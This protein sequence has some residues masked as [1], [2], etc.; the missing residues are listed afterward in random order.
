MPISFHWVLAPAKY[1]LGCVSLNTQALILT[2]HGGLEGTGEKEFDANHTDMTPGHYFLRGGRKPCVWV[3]KVPF[4]VSQEQRHKT[5]DWWLCGRGHAFQ[6]SQVLSPSSPLRETRWQ[7]MGETLERKPLPGRTDRTEPDTQIL[8][9]G[10]RQLPE[11]SPRL[12]FQIIYQDQPLTGVLDA[13]PNTAA[14]LT[15]LCQCMLML[16]L[17]WPQKHLRCLLYVC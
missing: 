14:V 11:L 13:C 7:M 17:A 9:I 1:Y 3:R 5:Q 16:S 2:A 12:T 15:N 4:L 6:R 8:C 10:K